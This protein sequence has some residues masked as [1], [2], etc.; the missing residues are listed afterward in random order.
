MTDTFASG[1]NPPYGSSAGMTSQSTSD[2]THTLAELERKLHELERELAAVGRDEQGARLVDEGEAQAQPGLEQPARAAAPSDP[3][4]DPHSAS[5]VSI[6]LEQLLQFRDRL[7]RVTRELVEEYTRL[8]PGRSV[9]HPGQPPA[10]EAFT[11][12]PSAVAPLLSPPPTAEPEDELLFEGHVE[13]GVGPFY[14]IGSLS[15][16]EQSLARVPHAIEASVRRFEA[17]HAVIDLRL[18]APT[19]LIREL[20]G[21]LGVHFSVRDLAPGRVSLTFDEG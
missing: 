21:V 13:L 18:S 17:S 3:P 1:P 11:Q 4:R 16:F 9:R 7:E 10:T 12:A 14:D 19:V 15:A 8:L 2:V 6:D 5:G 20:R